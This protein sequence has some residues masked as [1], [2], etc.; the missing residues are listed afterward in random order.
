M[1]IAKRIAL[2]R[3]RH[4]TLQSVL[5]DDVLN[6]TVAGDLENA[7]SARRKW[8]VVADTFDVIAHILMAVTGILAFV[9]SYM[10]SNSAVVFSNGCTSTLSVVCLKF[11]CY[12]AERCNEEHHIVCGT[13]AYFGTDT[14]LPLHGY[15]DETEQCP[16]TPTPISEQY[17]IAEQ[18]E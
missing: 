3:Q 18:A 5:V 11:A 4:C 15:M 9:A 13:L 14:I 7:L 16:P 6:P 17:P 8:K 12:A 1:Q 10:D 2:A